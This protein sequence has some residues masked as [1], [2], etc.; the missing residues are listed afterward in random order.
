M[1]RAWPAVVLCAWLL[2]AAP[3]RALDIDALQRQLHG[4][5][6][7]VYRFDEVRESPWQPAPVRSQGTLRAR[8]G[9]L[10]KVVES[11]RQET[12]RLL[13]DRLQLLR[14]GRP[15]ASEVRFSAVP[16]VGV[17]AN[18]LRLVLIGDLAQLGQAFELALTGDERQWVLHG[19]PRNPDG[20]RAVR[21]IEL[22]GSG[23]LLKALVFVDG[24]GERTFM[25]LEPLR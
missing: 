25:R 3:A 23:T 5:T 17:L 24:Q 15:E 13:P 12:W 21:S 6:Q 9:V 11:P 2:A 19:A 14:P 22:Q 18:A 8:D 4:A 10:E 16:A 20:R 7:P 1:T